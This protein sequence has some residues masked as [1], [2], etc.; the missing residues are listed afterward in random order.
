MGGE[1]VILRDHRTTEYH[2]GMN[3]SPE[4]SLMPC[5]SIFISLKVDITDAAIATNNNLLIVEASFSV[6]LAGGSFTSRNM[7]LCI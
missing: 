6:L 4:V 2:E 1:I 3:S 7:K 5:K